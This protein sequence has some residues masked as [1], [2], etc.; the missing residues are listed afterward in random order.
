M[1]ICSLPAIDKES[2]NFYSVSRGQQ[3]YSVLQCDYCHDWSSEH[4]VR[5]QSSVYLAKQKEEE[6]QAVL[7]LFS[8]FSTHSPNLKGEFSPT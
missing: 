3:C 2:R 7:N 6:R 5:I 8:T 1:F 4:W